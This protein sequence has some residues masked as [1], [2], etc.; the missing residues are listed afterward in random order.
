M[1]ETRLDAFF[2]N[3]NEHVM[4]MNEIMIMRM[5]LQNLRLMSKPRFSQMMLVGSGAFVIFVCYPPS[6]I[7][8]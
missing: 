1:K 6:S 4:I 5:M 2:I 3:K 7:E 8:P